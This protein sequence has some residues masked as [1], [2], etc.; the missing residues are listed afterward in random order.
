[1]WN[2]LER[3]YYGNR[4]SLFST[5]KEGRTF[6]FDVKDH[7]MH[8]AWS[9]HVMI[10]KFYVSHEPTA[11]EILVLKTRAILRGMMEKKVY[12]RNE[13]KVS[14]PPYKKSKR[15]KRIR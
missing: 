4:P 10:E 11:E 12:K 1:V 9:S 6:A 14:L 8:I 13:T 3:N 7:S 5:N 15:Y 2:D